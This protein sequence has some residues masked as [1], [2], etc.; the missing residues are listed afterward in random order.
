MTFFM[1]PN[2]ITIFVICSLFVTGLFGY[3]DYNNFNKKYFV[4]EMQS[5]APSIVQ[6][7]FDVGNGYNQLDSS[8]IHIQPE[9][10]KKYVFPLTDKPI[11]S[12][13][14]DPTDVPAVIRLKDAWIADTEGEVIK[15]LPIK[16]FR[17]TQQISKMEMSESILVLHTTENATDPII[18]IENSSV[19]NQIRWK[20]QIGEY[21][22]KY[23]GYTLL[24]FLCLRALNS[25]VI[26]ASNSS[27]CKS[28]VAPAVNKNKSS[29]HNRS[30]YAD[31]IRAFSICLIIVYH[32]DLNALET[33]T[34]GNLL[35]GPISNSF[36]HL[37]VSL[38]IIL[39][40][41]TLMLNYEHNFNLSTYIKKRFLSIYPLFWMTYL[42]FFAIKFTAGEYPGRTALDIFINAWGHRWFYAL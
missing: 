31:F 8:I 32:F 28:A 4:V 34:A 29:S 42:F 22:L 40:G 13:R 39:S 1:K 24:S 41:A 25:V 38:F 7:F 33:Q 19:E 2:R 16:D 17:P 37:G 21:G 20:N 23:L 12:I 9:G 10:I 26:S 30:F 27:S 14:F 6:V 5:S 11:K 15:K 3:Q 35:F 18:T 36:G